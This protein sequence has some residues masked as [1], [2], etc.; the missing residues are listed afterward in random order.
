MSDEDRVTI[1]GQEVGGTPPSPPLVPLGD[2]A[3]LPG[4][5]ACPAPD[6]IGLGFLDAHAQAAAAGLR[7]S[8][9]VW[10]TTVG[11]WGRVLDQR[12]EPKRRIRRGGR[13]VITVS[14]R[15]H[16]QVPDVRGLPLDDAIER[17]VWLG[18]V[19]LADVRRPSR[20]VAAGHVVATRPSAGALLAYGSV[21]ALT[22][23]KARRE[24][25]SRSAH[26]SPD[27]R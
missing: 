22:V 25:I 11:P 12:P 19:P 15:P 6:L 4:G 23:A 21:V 27:T 18:F 9:S 16:E 1:P 5:G 3:S 13:I 2:R 10:E 26:A 17:L 20:S 7:L 8:V 24:T 14:G